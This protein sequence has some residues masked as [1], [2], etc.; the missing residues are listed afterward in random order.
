MDRR[1]FLR[2][3]AIIA[4]GSIAAD[5]LGILEKLMARGRSM[6]GWTRAV[7]KNLVEYTELYQYVDGEYVMTMF[8]HV[9]PI[10]RHN[11]RMIMQKTL[12]SESLFL[13]PLENPYLLEGPLP[14]QFQGDP[15]PKLLVV[16]R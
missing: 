1:Q 16:S 6:I 3:S 15:T 14:V 5:Q 9:E 2:N 8:E 12:G 11:L 10:T 7:E 13:P 4:A